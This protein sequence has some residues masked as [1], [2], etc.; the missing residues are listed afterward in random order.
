MPYPVGSRLDEL[1]GNKR[2]FPGKVPLI[3]VPARCFPVTVHFARRTELDDYLGVAY[4]KVRAALSAR[5]HLHRC[6]YFG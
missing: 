4:K 3:H 5:S 1:T 2:L 6:P